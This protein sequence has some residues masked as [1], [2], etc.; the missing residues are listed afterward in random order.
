MVANVALSCVSH[1]QTAQDILI[2]TVL[3]ECPGNW[4]KA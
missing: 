1:I 3:E 2:Y 4:T